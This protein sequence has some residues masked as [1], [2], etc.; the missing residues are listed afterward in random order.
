MQYKVLLRISPCDVL[1]CE[2]LVMC[3]RCICIN[4]LVSFDLSVIE[5][6]NA[7]LR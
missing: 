3:T 1:G 2:R 7:V 5:S 6:Y 4:S